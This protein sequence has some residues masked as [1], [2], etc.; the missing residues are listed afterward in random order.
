VGA[1]HHP[2]HRPKWQASDAVVETVTKGR[3]GSGTPNHCMHGNA[4]IVEEVLD[5]RPF[6]YVTMPTLVPVADA[7]KVIVTYAFAEIPGGTRVEIR[8]GKPKP[9]DAA[10]LQAA[11]PG[12]KANFDRSLEN[13]GLLL[14]GSSGTQPVVDEPALPVS[15]ERFLTE[16]VHAH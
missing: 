9:K 1:F 8:V 2:R 5:W 4:T 11:G 6:D 13:L 12:F 14:A 10:F 15:S 7:P 3:R 16:P